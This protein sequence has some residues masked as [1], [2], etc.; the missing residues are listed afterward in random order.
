M[1]SDQ[2]LIRA[3]RNMVSLLEEEV[4]FYRKQSQDNYE[5]IHTLDSERAANA[6]LTEENERLRNGEAP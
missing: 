1:D 4:M 2:V 3:L 6:I 5:A